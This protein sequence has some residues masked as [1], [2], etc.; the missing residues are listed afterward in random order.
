MC[1]WSHST[2]RVVHILRGTFLGWIR[3][4]W[5]LQFC[6]PLPLS[7]LQ[8]PHRATHYNG[9]IK[10]PPH[11]CSCV[12][13]GLALALSAPLSDELI[14]DGGPQSHTTAEVSFFLMTTM[15]LDVPNQ[16]WDIQEHPFAF[17]VSDMSTVQPFQLWLC[18]AWHYLFVKICCLLNCAY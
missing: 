13:L 14:R 8:A 1:R 3:N 18:S 10:A 5:Y 16:L 4:M 6:N 17:R 11:T 9:L 2:G 15:S 7:T 12:Y